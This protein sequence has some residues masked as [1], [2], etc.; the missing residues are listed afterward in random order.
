[1]T[2]NDTAADTAAPAQA[3]GRNRRPRRRRLLAA[4][5][6]ILVLLAGYAIWTNTRPYTLEASTE[7]HATPALACRQNSLRR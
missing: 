5:A 6:A 3:R 4:L 2:M 1:M 7:I